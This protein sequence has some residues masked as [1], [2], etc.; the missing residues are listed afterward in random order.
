MKLSIVVVV[1]VTCSVL[2]QQSDAWLF[3]K[4]GARL[5]QRGFDGATPDEVA[6]AR[7]MFKEMD[8]AVKSGRGA[9]KR[10]FE[11]LEDQLEE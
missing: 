8:D 7:T 2:V 3:W 9:V 6:K 10:A 11:N 4:K 1:L 5:S